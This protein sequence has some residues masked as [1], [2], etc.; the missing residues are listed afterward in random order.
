MNKKIVGRIVKAV[1]GDAKG[2]FPLVVRDFDL[3]RVFYFLEILLKF[4][5]C[6]TKN[7]A[8]AAERFGNGRELRFL[9]FLTEK[10]TVDPEIEVIFLA[11][12]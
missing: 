8:L 1:V 5:L 4:D 9:F 3:A 7:K 2:F 12:F 6:F 10:K 11:F